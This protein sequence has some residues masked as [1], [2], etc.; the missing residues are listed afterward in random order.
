MKTYNVNIPGLRCPVTELELWD[1]VKREVDELLEA[2]K[3]QDCVEVKRISSG[4]CSPFEKIREDMYNDEK[5]KV[6]REIERRRLASD[7]ADDD[8]YNTSEDEQSKWHEDAQ[9]A[10]ETATEKSNEAFDEAFPF[11]DALDKIERLSVFE[12]EQSIKTVTDIKVEYFS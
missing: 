8:E 1:F 3:N 7:G 4:I 5:T 12:I 11:A 10:L 2:L 9:E 6:D